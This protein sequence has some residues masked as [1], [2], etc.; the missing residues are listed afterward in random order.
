M[1]DLAVRLEPIVDGVAVVVLDDPGHS[2]NTM[3][4]AYWAGMDAVLAELSASRESLRG[5]IVSSAKSTFFAGGDLKLLGAA[6]PGDEDAMRDLATRATRQ[7]RSLETLGVPVVAAINGSALGG[8]LEITLAC[9]RRIAVDTDT[10][11]LGLPEVT[12]GLLPAAN[13]LVR[14]VR[15]LGLRQALS[16]LLLAGTT[17]TP[18][19]AVEFGLI[20][21]LVGTADDLIPAARR[22]IAQATRTPAI[23]NEPIADANAAAR[24]QDV[25]ADLPRAVRRLFDGYPMPAP[26]AILHAACGGVGRDFES[27]SELE[28][29]A[30]VALVCGSV[31]TNLIRSKFFDMQRIKAGAARPQGYEKST[32]TK[33]AVIGAGMMGA[34]IA[35]V[36]AQA[37]MEV[38]LIDRDI[39]A[40]EKGKDSIARFLAKS[41]VGDAEPVLDRITPVDAIDKSAADTEIVIEAV[42]EDEDLKSSI[43]EQVDAVVGDH[44]LLASNTS[45]LP[46]TGLAQAV[47]NPADFIGL[48]FFSPVPRMQLVEVI[49]GKSTGPA[50]LARG[51]D[52]VRQLNKIPIVVSDSRGFF[53]S[54]VIVKRLIEAMAMVAEGVELE[55]IE[56]AAVNVGYPVGPLTLLDELTISLVETVRRQAREAAEASGQSWTEHPGDAVAAAMVHTHQR[57]GRAAGGGFYEYP[58]GVRGDF[59]SGLRQY[60]GAND[61]DERTVADRLLFAE[62]VDSFNCLDEG[63][64]RS[65][66]DANV[67]SLLGIGFPAWTGG[68]IQFANGYPGGAAAFRSR[69]NELAAA[70]GARFALRESWSEFV[71]AADA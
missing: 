21:E 31:S 48:H 59:W 38:T 63:V 52:V 53:T 14:S 43:F 40:A 50:T 55:L 60:C 17:Y 9:H 15:L 1:S 51:I 25:L 46:I 44:C 19:Q 68:V 71:E 69:A 4:E 29:E 49:A 13:G 5:V 47:Q 45:T 37:G 22:W 67:G 23:P 3:N 62:V 61:I 24:P 20:D 7:L 34:G 41:G 26:R 36:C 18:K 8:G 57:S 32:F 39:E 11:R 27:A 16:K 65:T 70:Y 42:F 6:R 2:A 35:Q 28:T 54:R 56:R 10:T 12:L 58:D 64:L 30:F 33:A 66:P